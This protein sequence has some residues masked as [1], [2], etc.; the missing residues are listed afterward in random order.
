MSDILFKTM[1]TECI[2]RGADACMQSKGYKYLLNYIHMSRI[3]STS[4]WWW[5][6]LITRCQNHQSIRIRITNR[7]IISITVLNSILSAWQHDEVLD[8]EDGEILLRSI[9][10]MEPDT[11]SWNSLCCFSNSLHS[12]S[13]IIWWEIYLTV[14]VKCPQELSKKRFFIDVVDGHL[15]LK[16]WNETPSMQMVSDQFRNQLQV[17]H[18]YAKP[19]RFFYLLQL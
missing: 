4:W 7:Q 6:I 9:D 5:N 1:V 11:I 14:H 2:K 16:I 13:P 10:S 19:E 12:T 15:L 3:Y 17:I 18:M 8:N